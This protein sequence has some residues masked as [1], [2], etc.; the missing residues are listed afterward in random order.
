MRLRFAMQYKPSLLGS[1]SAIGGFLM[2]AARRGGGGARRDAC[3]RADGE[4]GTRA[5]RLRRHMRPACPVRWAYAA[6]LAGRRRCEHVCAAIA[7]ST[8]RGWCARETKGLRFASSGGRAQVT[9]PLRTTALVATPVVAQCLI[10]QR[11]QYLTGRASE[12]VN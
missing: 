9:M 11:S 7:T 5:V 8:W 3:A 10:I 4:S 1:R 2:R 6:W 12:Q